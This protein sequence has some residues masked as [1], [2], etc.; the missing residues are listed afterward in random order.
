MGCLCLIEAVLSP[1]GDIRLAILVAA[2]TI[3]LLTGV[4]AKGASPVNRVLLCKALTGSFAT[5]ALATSDR[6]SET[7]L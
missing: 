6:S 7:S 4:W 5:C 1:K 2:P 3:W